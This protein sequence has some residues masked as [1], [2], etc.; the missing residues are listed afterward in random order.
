VHTSLLAEW[1][2]VE[3]ETS[4]DIIRNVL[5]SKYFIY[6]TQHPLEERRCAEE[7]SVMESEDMPQLHVA[8]VTNGIT[9]VQ[10]ANAPLNPIE[11]EVDQSV[12]GAAA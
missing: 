4:L 9:P 3:D 1:Q 12:I 10:A 5:F 8:T 7:F 11:A 6:I 2:Q